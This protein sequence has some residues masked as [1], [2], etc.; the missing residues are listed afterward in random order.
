MLAADLEDFASQSLEFVADLVNARSLAIWIDDSKR[1]R[2]L[3]HARVF[4]KNNRWKFEIDDSDHFS[5]CLS[6]QRFRKPAF[7]LRSVFGYTLDLP[8]RWSGNVEIEYP[9]IT[10]LSPKQHS[11]LQNLIADLGQSLH[12][13]VMKQELGDMERHQEQEDRILQDLRDLTGNLSKELYCLSSVSTVLGQSYDVAEILSRVIE[14][15][16][17]ILKA[18]LGAIYLP[19]TD[20]CFT[21]WAEGSRC[22]RSEDPWFRKH[23]EARLDQFWND[24]DSAPLT[25][26]TISGCP[27]LPSHLRV[28]LASQGVQSVFEF[29]LRSRDELFGLGL[30][31]FPDDRVQIAGTRLFMITLNMI[32]LFLENISLM[33]D[34]ERQVRMKSQEILQMEKHQRFLLDQVGHSFSS[35]R[36]GGS[37]SVGRILEELERSR[38]MALLG[39]VASGVAHRIRNPLSNIVSALHLIQ[40]EETTTEEKDELFDRLTERVETMNRMITEFVQYTRIPELNL[41]TE[42]INHSLENSLC[43]FKGWMDL[44]NIELTKSF[45]RDLPLTKLDLTLMNQ[46]YHNIIKNALEAMYSHGRLRVSTRRLRIDNGPEPHLEFAEIAFHDSGAGIRRDDIGKVLNPFYSRK[47]DG[48]GLGL[49][50]VEHIVRAHGGGAKVESRHGQGTNV[51]LYLPVR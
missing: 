50:I 17:P 26:Q 21:Y 45:A 35:T 5:T 33:R 19:E 24:P 37:S 23:F 51:I 2:R 13:V 47:T 49:A 31:G 12:I 48:L 32:G 30:L 6:S 10:I 41:T 15:T 14:T 27:Q 42:S 43:S 25:T 3:I 28:R 34:L 40:H 18:D 16:L 20:Q 38:R 44:A 7:S 8:A 46:V 36:A 4:R 29:T 39:E 11:E 9:G 22:Q 1:T